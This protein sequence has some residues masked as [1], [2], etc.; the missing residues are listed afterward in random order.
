M[1]QI[2]L[3]LSRVRSLFTPLLAGLFL[4]ACCAA[5]PAP[6]PV[7]EPPAPTPAAIEEAPVDVV[8]TPGDVPVGGACGEGLGDCDAGGF[9]Q[10]PSETP[11]GGEGI[12]GVC[13]ARPTGCR[14]DCPGVC[15]CNG[16]RFCN[17]CSAEARGFT[18]RHDGNCEEPTHAP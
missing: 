4:V 11:C 16:H 12:A 18:V 17:T 3:L 9:C 14:R 15:G 13:V 10:Y 7:A 6:A 2:L 1:A 5:K 8:A